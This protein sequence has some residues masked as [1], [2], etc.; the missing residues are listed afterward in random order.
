M[1][2][3][4][5]P[6]DA[7]QSARLSHPDKQI[8]LFTRRELQKTPGGWKPM[9][10]GEKRISAKR[11]ALWECVAAGDGWYVAIGIPRFDRLPDDAKKGP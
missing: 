11:G 8:K 7:L 5:S 10:A 6:E 3:T 4:S 9:Q 2:S 1:N